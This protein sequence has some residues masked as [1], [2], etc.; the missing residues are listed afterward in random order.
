M[1]YAIDLMDWLEAAVGRALGEKIPAL[2]QQSY[3]D[4][5]TASIVV[6]AIA[7]WKFPLAAV[8]QKVGIAITIRNVMVC[9]PAP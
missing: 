8:T 6:A 5:S 1:Q 4:Y 2:K 3:F 7:P 9:K